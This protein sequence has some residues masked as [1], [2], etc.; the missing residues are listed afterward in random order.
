MKQLLCYAIYPTDHRTLVAD[1]VV[2]S[3]LQLHLFANPVSPCDVIQSVQATMSH[4]CCTLPVC[5]QLPSAQ[6]T[7][8]CLDKYSTKLQDLTTLHRGRVLLYQLGEGGY[9]V[10]MTSLCH[11]VHL[12]RECAYTGIILKIQE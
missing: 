7:A 12:L 9:N 1:L 5:S 10:R 8:K 3:P 11:P 4:S 6:I 2:T